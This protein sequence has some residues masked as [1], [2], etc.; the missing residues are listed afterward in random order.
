MRNLILTV[1]TVIPTIL[2]GHAQSIKVTGTAGGSGAY[3]TQ[4]DGDYFTVSRNDGYAIVDLQGK[5]LMSGVKAPRSSI[6][7]RL[8]LYHGTLFVDDGSGAVVLK[9]ATGEPLGA[10]KYKAVLPFETDN[11][12]VSLPSAPGTWTV[13]FIDTAGR[14]IVRYDLKKYLAIVRPGANA[15]VYGP[16]TLGEF[17][18][19]SDG[20]IPIRSPV[21]G[22][23]GYLNKRLELAIPFTFKA[24]QPFTNGM[25]AVQNADGNWGFINTSGKL[26]IPYTYS[27]PAGPFRSGRAKVQAKDG[28][29][30][31]INKDNVVVIQPQY[32][33]V[34]N[35]YKGYALARE[36]ASLP[37]VLIDTAG[38]VVATYSKDLLY[39][40][41]STNLSM[42]GESS[43]SPFYVP[44][45]LQELVD[46]GMGI[47][48]KGEFYGLMD[49]KGQPVLDFKYIHLSDLH[50]GRLFAHYYVYANN[51]PFNQFGIIDVKGN[52]IV[53]IVPSQF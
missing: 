35:F 33:Y 3:I 17:T 25:A 36:G 2:H 50:K 23:V 37:I 24:E 21:T 46:E 19:F 34:T 39:I 9:R 26:V 48:Q 4:F 1:I 40:D 29:F 12:V 52:W 8:S 7:G 47:F 15:R 13:A 30:G 49:N 51:A 10:T 22:K 6:L 43:E 14:E 28:K 42:S 16:T 32:R 18:P 45:T 20:L 38:S 44:A 53:E 5:T 27:L 31:F 11:T 41:N